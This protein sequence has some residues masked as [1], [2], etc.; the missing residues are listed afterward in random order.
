LLGSG[1]LDEAA[2]LYE[3]AL[4]I[5]AETKQPTFAGPFLGSLATLLHEQGRLEAAVEHFERALTGMR[6]TGNLRY[7]GLMLGYLAAARAGLGQVDRAE[8]E[9][10][11]AERRSAEV[12]DPRH[13]FC[14]RLHRAFVDVARAKEASSA[15]D[16][17][18]A[19]LGLARRTRLWSRRTSL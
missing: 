2:Q 15:G 13:V 1:Q 14:N 4:A 10:A 19:A 3:E 6:E 11:E 17:E 5:L 8:A 9:V 18:R 16:L 12:G 7:E